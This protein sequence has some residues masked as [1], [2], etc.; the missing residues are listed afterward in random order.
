[1]AHLEYYLPTDTNN[2][3]ALPVVNNSVE[4]PL[5]ES[6]VHESN[7]PTAS[8]QSASSL[9][10]DVDAWKKTGCAMFA[11]ILT[12]SKSKPT[13][14][15]KFLCDTGNLGR[16]LI[17]EKFAQTLKW[18]SH[19]CKHS[20]K[21]AQGN[22]VT[23]T[24]ET[25]PVSF[26]IQGHEQPFQW[27]FLIIRDLCAPGVFGIDFFNHFD[28]A[29]QMSKSGANFLTFGGQNPQRVPLV[30]PN[31]PN[32]PEMHEDNRF[33]GANVFRQRAKPAQ[34]AAGEISSDLYR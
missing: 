14:S 22:R 20:I 5:N 33:A 30:S 34:T 25:N 10:Q 26:V 3:R 23:I 2:V 27:R 18:E 31:A 6:G 1:M 19:P 13:V 16:S 12:G 28:V 9:E 7:N 8:V 11:R 15:A 29:I 17:S 21:S 4:Q 32:L 24:G